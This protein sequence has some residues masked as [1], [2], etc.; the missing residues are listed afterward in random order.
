MV[1]ASRNAETE[2]EADEDEGGPRFGPTIPQLLLLLLAVAFL[3]SA[4]TWRWMSRDPKPNAVDVGFYDDMTVHHFQAI[5]M[6]SV[7]LRRG[8]D[9][10]LLMVA[11]EIQF[12]QIGDIREMQGALQEWERDGTPDV[13]MEWMGMSVPPDA[14]PGMATEEQLAE[15][16]R[17]R[18]AKLDEVFTRLMINHHAGGVHMADNAGDRGDLVRGTAAAIAELQRGEINEINLR[19]EQLGFERHG[20]VPARPG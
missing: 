9:Q 10:V 17:V 11:S 6:A 12:S 1:D 14:M 5:N 4:A 2:N 20:P 3:S 15:I 8:S 18:G 19:R 13:A 16:E 7:Y